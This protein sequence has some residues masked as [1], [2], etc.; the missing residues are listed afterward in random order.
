MIPK[1][2]LLELS[3]QYGLLPTTIQ[4]DYIIGWLLRA[5]SQHPVLSKWVFKG[6]TCLKKCYFETYRFSEDLDFT[7]PADQTINVELITSYFESAI[8]WIETNSGIS[9]PRQDWK[10][11]NYQN[12]REKTSY[13]VKI[14]YIGPLGSQGLPQKS[15]QRVKFDLTQD[16]IIADTPQRRDL[17]HDYTD[18]FHPTPQVLCYSI[19]EILAEKTRALFERNGRARDVYDVVNISRNFR[20]EIN[21]EQTKRI[22]DKKFHFKYIDA[23][24]VK[25]IIGA[26]DNGVLKANWEHQLAHQINILPPV[27][28]YL[29]DLDDAIAWWLEPSIA[30]PKLQPMPQAIGN[31]IPRTLFPSVNWQTGPSALDQIRYASRNKLCATISYHGSMRLVEPYSLRYP[32]TGNEILHVWELEK[33]G[34]PSNMHKSYKTHEISSASI[35]N[36][37]F[38][39]KWAVEL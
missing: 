3:K 27:D 9:F 26:I 29:S 13:Q 8:G 28:T 21:P 23:P 15:L 36:R 1:A 2:Q 25:Q 32:S 10:I 37:T 31:P 6:G 7:I 17:H 38:I 19:E 20:N 18:A 5:I 35:S 30:K 34:R 16:E 14:P 39:P 33:N 12:P 22:A 24:S 4:K 11:E